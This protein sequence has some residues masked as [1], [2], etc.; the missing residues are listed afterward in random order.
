M[1]GVVNLHQSMSALGQTSSRDA[2]VSKTE[3]MLSLKSQLL[4]IYPCFVS[5][6]MT[7]T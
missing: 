3:V 4:T 2:L 5:N 1:A 6:I 7:M